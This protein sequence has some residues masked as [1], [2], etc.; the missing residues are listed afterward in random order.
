VPQLSRVS[1]R[2]LPGVGVLSSVLVLRWAQKSRS[3]G[4]L[5]GFKDHD[6]RTCLLFVI[7]IISAGAATA[8]QDRLAAK[9]YSILSHQR[10]YDIRIHLTRF[11]LCSQACSQGWD[12]LA[13]SSKHVRGFATGFCLSRQEG[14]CLGRLRMAD[15]PRDGESADW[16]DLQELY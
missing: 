9:V 13:P 1:N 7:Q 6:M 3:I 10:A 12:Q 8:P 14:G 5:G 16:R 15:P 11:S 2:R 4:S